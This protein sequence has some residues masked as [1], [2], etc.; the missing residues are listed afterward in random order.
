MT[1]YIDGPPPIRIDEPGIYRILVQGRLDSTW[2]D[3][4]DGLDLST[5]DGQDG[6]V[7][8]SLTGPITDQAALHSILRRIRDLGLTLLLVELVT[9]A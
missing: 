2:S 4:F 8:T 3:W 7:V 9:T 1:S 6:R 5:V